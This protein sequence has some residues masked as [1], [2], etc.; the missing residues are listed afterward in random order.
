MGKLQNATK[1]YGNAG[2]PIS[3]CFG[4]GSLNKLA[5][6]RLQ[7][8]LLRNTPPSLCLPSAPMSTIVKQYDASLIA[9]R[10]IL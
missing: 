2:P 4:F 7:I 6:K 8:S 9:R 10:L 5:S 3:I 1:T